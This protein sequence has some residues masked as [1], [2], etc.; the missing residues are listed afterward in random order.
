MDNDITE[1]E[2]HAGSTRCR[3]FIKKAWAYLLQNTFQAAVVLGVAL[4]LTLNVYA[5][6]DALDQLH[7]GFPGEMLMRMLKVVA[8]PRIITNII[9]GVSGLSVH[10]SRKIILRSTAYILCTTLIAATVG[11]TL[12]VLSKP[13]VEYA[14]KKQE[15]EEVEDQAFSTVDVL[16]D[17][18][19]NMVPHNLIRACFQRFKTDRTDFEVEDYDS[20][21]NSS[22]MTN[23]TEVGG[24]YVNGVNTLGLIV[25]SLVFGVI[26]NKMGEKGE[27]LVEVVT[28]INEATKCLI[29]LILCYLPVGVLFMIASNVVEIYNWETIFKLGQFVL[30]VM[31]GL[32]IHGAIVLPL[33]Y[34]VFTRHNPFAVIRGVFPALMTALVTSSSS[35]TS[36]V[37]FRCCEER[38]KIDKRILRFILPIGTSLNMN[39][40]T[41]YEVVA[42]VFIAQL[43]KIQLDFAHLLTIAVT[44]AVASTG[45]GLPATGAVTTL[46]VLAAVGLPAKQAST[47]VVVEWLLD[48][49]NTAINVLV[50][51]FGAA[52]IYRVSTQ[53]LEYMTRRDAAILENIQINVSSSDDDIFHSDSSQNEDIGL[54]IL[55]TPPEYVSV[56]DSDDQNV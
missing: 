41:I 2:T 43:N 14:V 52:L 17:L 56:Q 11:I 24:H 13:G 46:F 54:Q 30:T 8:A 5:D 19:R 55:H 22:M 48:P 44:A 47:L 10:S 53:E 12:V 7:I 34:F 26:L 36:Q 27:I 20:N 16:M 3:G 1:E 31:I 42:A 23:A 37:I 40:S 4:G 29:N 28:V 32:L 6:R 45:A 33:M 51:C 25:W 50:N 35:A 15:E 18:I 21:N 49:C 38:L 39:G 9:M